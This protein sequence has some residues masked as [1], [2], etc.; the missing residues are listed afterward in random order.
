MV[1]SR[2]NKWRVKCNGNGVVKMWKSNYKTK[3]IK[4]SKPLFIV[5]L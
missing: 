2:G 1:F 5:M 3:K 4:L